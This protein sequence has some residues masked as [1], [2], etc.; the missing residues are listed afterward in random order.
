MLDAFEKLLTAAQ[1]ASWQCAMVLCEPWQQVI[2]FNSFHNLSFLNSSYTIPDLLSS[3]QLV[4]A[5][6]S[7]PALP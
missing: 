2:V 1:V 3:L 5:G 7:H 6:R 4:A